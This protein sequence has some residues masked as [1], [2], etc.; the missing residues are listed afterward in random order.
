MITIDGLRFAYPHGGFE[1]QVSHLAIARGEHT[2]IIGPSGSGKTTLL[3]CMAGIA[4]PRAGEVV[5]D[6]ERLHAMGDAAR[7]RFRIRRVGFVFQDFALV[8]YL[9]V[10]E[11]ILFPYYINR[12]LTLDRA[13]RGRAAEL[14]KRMGL[15]SLA[16]R[17]VQRLS[18][19]EQ[20]RVALCRALLTCPALLLADEPTGNLDPALKRRLLDLLVEQARAHGSTLV[21]VTHDHSLLDRFPRVI[22]LAEGTA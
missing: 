18:Q 6:G 15:G 10:G 21:M 14:A 12:A 3:H 2:A 5:V 7:R 13:V 11:N 4:V 20:Q 9:N 1:L 22:D 16:R 19:G 8:D 17:N